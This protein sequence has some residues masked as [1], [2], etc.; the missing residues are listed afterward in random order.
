M[1][2]KQ[3]TLHKC[4]FSW[5]RDCFPDS[6]QGDQIRLWK[7]RPKSSPSRLL[8]KLKH[9]FYRGNKQP[10]N[11]GYFCNLQK[12][13]HS[14]QSPIGENSPNLV[15]LIARLSNKKLFSHFYDL[16]L[17]VFVAKKTNQRNSVPIGN[18][19]SGHI[20]RQHSQPKNRHYPNWF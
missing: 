6:E 1:K 4:G 15:T 5:K 10:N 9:N 20:V 14:K 7:N 11:L 16:T 12:A 18:I 2:F 17:V 19:Q 3:F 13:T 8:S